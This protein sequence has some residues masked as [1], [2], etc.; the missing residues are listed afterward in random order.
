LVR[1]IQPIKFR[2]NTGSSAAELMYLV[3]PMTQ[4]RWRCR[5]LAVVTGLICTASS[6]LAQIPTTKPYGSLVVVLQDLAPSA[7][8]G[9]PKIGDVVAPALYPPTSTPARIGSAR[10]GLLTSLYFGNV[11][12]H[13]LDAHSTFRALDAG[14]AEGN[15]LMR[16]STDHP[17]AFASMKAAATAG[18]IYVAEK[19]RKKHPR[20]AVLFMVGI[21]AASALIVMHNYRAVR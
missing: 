3:S 18:T 12:L 9:L 6:A 7:P 11:A 8:P 15:P 13:A 16:W 10:R 21:N 20:R 19:I 14:H 2:K 17:L 5:T 1:S 4:I